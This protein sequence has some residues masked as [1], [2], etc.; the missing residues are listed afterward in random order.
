MMKPSEQRKSIMKL[1]TLGGQTV[2]D[3][4]QVKM[5]LVGFGNSED[6]FKCG[7]EGQK[8]LCYLMLLMGDSDGVGFSVANEVWDRGKIFN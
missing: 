3:S 7:R 5:V 6:K 4:Q 1:S 2:G 8:R